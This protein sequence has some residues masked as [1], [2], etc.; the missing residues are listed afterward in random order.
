MNMKYGHY[1]FDIFAFLR[2]GGRDYMYGVLYAHYQDT[3]RCLLKSNT[4]FVKILNL[5]CYS[6][7]S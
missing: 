3:S 1:C 4:T 2:L 5:F 7:N 6:Y